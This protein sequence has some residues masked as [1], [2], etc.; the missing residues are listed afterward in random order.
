M[1][2]QKVS[3][4][5][6]ACTDCYKNSLLIKKYEDLIHLYKKK[7]VRLSGMSV[8]RISNGPT[9]NTLDLQ[10]S[11]VP[12]TKLFDAL[13]LL[14]KKRCETFFKPQ[15]GKSCK[16]FLLLSISNRIGKWSKKFAFEKLKKNRGK[17][18]G[19]II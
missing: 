19:E 12:C 16:K 5:T 3:D 14:F 15:F 2:K 17:D 18:I 4:S 1:L 13:S 9:C 7:Q 10:N 6:E 8:S 11:E